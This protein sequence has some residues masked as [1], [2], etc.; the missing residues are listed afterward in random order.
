MGRD[1]ALI[2]MNGERSGCDLNEWG[3]IRLRSKWMGRDPSLFIGWSN[4]T[5]REYAIKS[6]MNCVNI[7]SS[8]TQVRLK[9]TLFFV[10]TCS[11]CM[12]QMSWRGYYY[13]N[14]GNK[15]NMQGRRNFSY[16][17][18]NNVTENKVAINYVRHCKHRSGEI[19]NHFEYT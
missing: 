8:T 2:K 6:D 5:S 13:G 4:S 17:V 11:L 1:Q 9:K 12:H 14:S 7:D 3:E 10:L 15:Q 16:A 19:R 18:S